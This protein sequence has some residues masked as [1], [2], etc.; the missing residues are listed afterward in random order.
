MIR[1]ATR[2]ALAATFVAVFA[3]LVSQPPAALAATAQAE[4]TMQAQQK[5]NWCWSASGVS[6][7]AH[8]GSTVTQNQFC[9]LAKNL[10]PAY[11]CPNDQADLAQ[12]RNGFSKLGFTRPGTYLSNYLTY[13][14]V[15]TQ[16]DYGQPIETRILWKSGGG[17]MHVL[18]GYDAA[19]SWVYWGDPWPDNYRYN[20]ATYNYYVNNSTFG[21]TH[22]LTGIAR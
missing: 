11:A 2:S 8:H 16:L 14:A 7:A 18:Y 12:V 22:T 20:W 6:I 13:S 9:A 21:W 3:W 17:H 15:R 5:T 10:N 1:P 4:F 19:K